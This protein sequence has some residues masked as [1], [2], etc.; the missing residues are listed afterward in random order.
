MTA[1][2]WEKLKNATDCHICNKSLIKDEFFSRLKKA[3]KAVIGANG[4][5]GAI[6]W[7]KNS[8]RRN[9]K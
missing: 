6:T 3:G 1:E 5:K 7:C 4:T 9:K 8:S 2:D